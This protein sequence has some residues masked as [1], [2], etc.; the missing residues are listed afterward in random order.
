[1]CSTPQ[2][3]RLSF[4]SFSALRRNDARLSFVLFSA[5][6]SVLHAVASAVTVHASRGFYLIVVFPLQRGTQ[7]HQHACDRFYEVIMK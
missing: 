3:R 5:V 2:F 4:F 7:L 1:M 6:A